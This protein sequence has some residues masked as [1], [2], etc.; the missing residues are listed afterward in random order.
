MAL[1][2]ALKVSMDT[3]AV[4]SGLGR[5]TGMFGGVARGVGKQLKFMGKGVLAGFGIVGAV[6]TAVGA[7]TVGTARWAKNIKN[8]SNHTGVSVKDTLALREAFNAAGL[9]YYNEIISILPIVSVQYRAGRAF[10]ASRKIGKTHQNIIVFYKGDPSKCSSHWRD[11]EIV[12]REE[13][14]DNQGNEQ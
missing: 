5:I 3:K 14:I 4:K 11:R 7:M 2:A 10:K 12:L 8:I 13:D 9:C 1:G 6:G